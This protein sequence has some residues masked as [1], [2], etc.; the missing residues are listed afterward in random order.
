MRSKARHSH[1]AQVRSTSTRTDC[2]GMRRECANDEGMVTLVP[3]I[4]DCDPL[5]AALLIE[6]RGQTGEDL[7]VG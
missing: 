5:A 1:A 6:C 7:Q 2:H 3:D 4:T